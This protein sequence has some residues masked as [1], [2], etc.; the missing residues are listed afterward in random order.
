MDWHGL[1]GPG[2]RGAHPAISAKSV[3]KAFNAISRIQWRARR[4]TGVLFL[5]VG[6]YYALKYVF[7]VM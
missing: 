1:A 7:D 6:V 3:G 2:I 4:V 5:I